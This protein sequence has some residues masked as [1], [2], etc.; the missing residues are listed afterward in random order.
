MNIEQARFNMI[1]QQIRTWDVLD[2]GVL[3]LLARVPRED[4]VPLPYRKLA[5]ADT[6]IA[7]N[8]GQ[9][10]MPPKLEAR[11]IQA[12]SI[13]PSDVIL[14]IGTGSG[15]L[16]AL[17]ASLAE[18]VYSVDI[19]DEFRVSTQRKLAAHGITNVT[20]ETGDAALGWDRHGPY[21]AIALTGSLP[22][23]S[24]HFQQQLNIGGRL[25]MITGTAPAME[26][27]LITRRGEAR[28]ECES[29]FE[30]NLPPLINAPQPPRFVL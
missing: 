3:D 16:T 11:L 5:F 25:F 4:F 14:E 28:W 18:H 2:Q 23:F 12:L 20:L 13:K 6:P 26:A 17:L 22:I 29:L 30:T 9:V 19:F 27:R 10:M 8:H 15:Y 7:L 24:D 21:D 1:E